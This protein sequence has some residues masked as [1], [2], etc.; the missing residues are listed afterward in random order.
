[1]GWSLFAL[2]FFLFAK[3]FS[4][5][6]SWGW[7]LAAISVV[8]YALILGR[9]FIAR[10]I[11]IDK[12]QARFDT[13]PV[14]EKTGV[15]LAER[16]FSAGPLYLAA[17]LGIALLIATKVPSADINRIV[18]GAFAIPIIW[19]MGALHATVD[20]TRW[21]VWLTPLGLVAL[22]AALYFLM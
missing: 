19:A 3:A 20:V 17:S 16:L 15:T 6:L 7:T 12:R 21:R 22:S 9:F 5:S 18:F 10:Q 11:G 14:R 1:L 4:V 2:S 13:A 8:G